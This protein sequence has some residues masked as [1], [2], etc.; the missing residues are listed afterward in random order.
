MARLFIADNPGGDLQLIIVTYD[1]NLAR[2]DGVW[3]LS[4]MRFNFKYA[5]GNADLVAEARRR[6]SEAD[7]NTGA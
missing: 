4:L 1:L 5:S 6:A 7:G 3:K 2:A